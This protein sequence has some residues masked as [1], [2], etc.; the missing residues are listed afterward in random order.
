VTA[1][2]AALAARLKPET[3]RV[4]ARLFA[5]DVT[6]SAAQAATLKS[7]TTKASEDGSRF[8]L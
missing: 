8:R 6:L 4:A 1:G 7:E 3:V 2:G 5:L